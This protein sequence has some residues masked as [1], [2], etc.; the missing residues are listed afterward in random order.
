MT[1]LRVWH[2]LTDLGDGVVLLPCA[3]LFLAWLLA[4]PATRHTGWLWLAAVLVVGGGVALSRVQYMIWGLYPAGWNFIGLSGHSALS[5]LFWP[6]AGALVTGRNR[7]GLRAAMV[8]LGTC[9]ALAIAISSLVSHDHSLSEVALG[10]LWGALVAAVFLMLT[11]RHVTEVPAVRKW[12]I[13]SVL[14]LVI[15]TFGHGFPTRRVLGWIA[16]R[17]SGHAAIYTR[18]NLGPKARLSRNEA[19]C[20]NTGS[21]AAHKH[22]PL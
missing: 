5:F 22:A 1:V 21:P 20:R 13:V 2:G 4:S 12:M 10:A 16:L 3:V 18:C 6:A 14:L 15:I 8:A 11:W 17:V 9:L 19:D 7:P